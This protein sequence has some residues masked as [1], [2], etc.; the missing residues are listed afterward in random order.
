MA[1]V[2]RQRTMLHAYLSARPHTH[3]SMDEILDYAE[4]NDI[5]TATVYR[6]LDKLIKEGQLCKY[7]THAAKGG[8]CFQWHKSD[9]KLYHFVCNDCGECFHVECPHLEKMDAHFSDAHGFKPDLAM[10]VFRGKCASCA[11][12]AASV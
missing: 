9:C 8:P 7:D 3:I 1:Y 12:K 6:Y 2:T 5:G 11:G 4:K 10:T